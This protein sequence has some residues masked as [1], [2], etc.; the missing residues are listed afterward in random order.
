MVEPEPDDEL[1]PSTAAPPLAVVL[2]VSAEPE[3]AEDSLLSDAEPLVSVPVD[4]VVV[5]VPV[6]DVGALVTVETSP[7]GTVRSGAPSVE[8][9]TAPPPPQPASATTAATPATPVRTRCRVRLSRLL[10]APT[11]SAGAGMRDSCS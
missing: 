7:L 5:P 6:V 2:V 3:L 10:R 1:P 9:L 11:R 4:V 8:L